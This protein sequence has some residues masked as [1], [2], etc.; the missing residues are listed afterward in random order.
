MKKITVSFVE[1]SKSCGRIIFNPNGI[2]ICMIYL[3]LDGFWKIDGE[4]FGHGFIESSH[5]KLVCNKI[6]EMNQGFGNE[7]KDYFSNN[8]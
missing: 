5:M 3:D 2:E 7:L 6:D 4:S 8:F 1:L